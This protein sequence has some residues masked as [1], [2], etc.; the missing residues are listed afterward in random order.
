VVSLMSRDP[1]DW[2]VVSGQLSKFVTFNVMN[3]D[4]EQFEEQILV[5]LKL[6]TVKSVPEYVALQGMFTP[7]VIVQVT[8]LV[9]G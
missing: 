3:E 1:I 8:E 7:D 6:S 9:P 5:I 4:P 2:L